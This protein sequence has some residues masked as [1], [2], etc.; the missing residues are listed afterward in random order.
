LAL[1]LRR[2]DNVRVAITPLF[3]AINSRFFTL[4][5]TWYR[6]RLPAQSS[7]DVLELVGDALAQASDVRAHEGGERV[8]IDHPLVAKASQPPVRSRAF[9]R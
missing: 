1:L 3:L 7:F 4:N 8:P 9:H 5:S 2:P 6:I